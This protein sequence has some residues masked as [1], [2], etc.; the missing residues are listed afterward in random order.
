[1]QNWTTDDAENTDDRGG[2]GLAIAETGDRRPETGKG[3]LAERK[4]RERVLSAMAGT[5]PGESR[6]IQGNPGKSKQ[7]KP[8]R[9]FLGLSKGGDLAAKRR[10]ER[11]KGGAELVRRSTE[12]AAASG[13]IQV[14]PSKSNQFVWFFGGDAGWVFHMRSRD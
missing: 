9:F 10:K 7:I 5:D 13:K 14:N 4:C 1:L 12:V 11:E 8:K 6:E 2:G 3:E